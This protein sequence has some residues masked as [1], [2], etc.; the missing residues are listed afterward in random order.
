MQ[1]A[2][3]AIGLAALLAAPLTAN[4]V[5][6]RY[7]IGDRDGFGIGVTADETPDATTMP[8]YDSPGEGDGT[9]KWF[10]DQQS[11]TFDFDLPKYPVNAAR[12]EASTGGQG[13]NSY[14]TCSLAPTPVFLRDAL[15]GYLTVGDLAPFPSLLTGNDTFRFRPF[16]TGSAVGDRWVTD[17]LELTLQT[18]AVPEPSTLALSGLGL[19][20]ARRRKAD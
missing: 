9:D 11:L 19:G 5:P 16:A 17:Y 6:V 10:C 13:Y 2:V 1:L 3:F 7:L 15:I 14:D 12:L 4:A 20:F 8:G 18:R